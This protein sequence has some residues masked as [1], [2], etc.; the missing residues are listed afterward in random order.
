MSLYARGRRWEYEVKSRLEASGWL[1]C[2][3]A[4][5]KPFDL[6]AFRPGRLPMWVECK[7]GR[8]PSRGITQ[9]LQALATANGARYIVV[10]KK[11]RQNKK[12]VRH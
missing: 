7:L 9:G 4:S 12:E 8:R 5:S 2:R 3:C 6:I 10:V 11:S 1:V